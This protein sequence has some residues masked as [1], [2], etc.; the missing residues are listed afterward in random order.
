M[1]AWEYL[2]NNDQ[3]SNPGP[4]GDPTS[5]DKQP[6]KKDPPPKEPSRDDPKKDRRAVDDPA[7]PNSPQT[8]VDPR[9]GR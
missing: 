5:V 9:A 6:P 1:T 7:A 2:M 8:D 3:I 4:I